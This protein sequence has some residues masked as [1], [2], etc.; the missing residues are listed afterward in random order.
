MFIHNINVS[1]KNAPWWLIKETVNTD[2]KG[3]GWRE[4]IFQYCSLMRLMSC[5]LQK[6]EIKYL[7]LGLDVWECSYDYKHEKNKNN[8]DQ[9]LFWIPVVPRVLCTPGVPDLRTCSICQMGLALDLW[10]D[11]NRYYFFSVFVLLNPIPAITYSFVSLD[12]VGSL[13][14][15]GKRI[16]PN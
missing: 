5:K 1:S 8:P 3:L 11:C 14:V 9:L 16:L 2:Q 4:L 10:A 13:R 15:L 6:W 12:I 7:L